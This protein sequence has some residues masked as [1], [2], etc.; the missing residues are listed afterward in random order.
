MVTGAVFIDLTKAF[1]TVNHSI[2]LSKLNSLGLLDD[3]TAIGLSHTFPT[4]LNLLPATTVNRTKQLYRLEYPKA[5]SLDLCCLQYTLTTYQ[6]VWNSV[7]LLFT[8]MTPSYLFLLNLFRTL[9]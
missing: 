5:P 7:T 4:D 2:L 9:N 8:Q 6:T 3:S 1:D